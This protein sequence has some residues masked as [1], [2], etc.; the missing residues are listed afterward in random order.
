MEHSNASRKIFSYLVQGDK[1]IVKFEN[2]ETED[3]PNTPEEENKIE[4]EMEK[5]LVEYYT[6]NYNSNDEK[7]SK[8]R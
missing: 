2:G 6:D 7:F 5:Q 3:R 8:R 4:R 1:I